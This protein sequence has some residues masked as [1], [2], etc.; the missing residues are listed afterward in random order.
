[1]R[2]PVKKI[3]A[4]LLRFCTKNQKILNFI[5]KNLRFTSNTADLIIRNNREIFIEICDQFPSAI[6]NGFRHI[7]RVL[8]IA[9]LYRLPETNVIIDIGAADGEI[10]LLF[11]KAYPEAI[12]YAFEPIK[13]AFTILHQNVKENPH[14]LPINKA[15]GNTIGERIIHVSES[16]RSSSIFEIENDIKNT[17][18]AEQLKYKSDEKINISRLDDEIPKDIDVNIVKIDVQ[19]YE[20]EVLKG[21]EL[22]LLRTKL[23]VLEMQNHN[24]YIDAPKYFVLDEYLRK[25]GFQLYDIVPSIREDNK[26]YEWDGIYINADFQAKYNTPPKDF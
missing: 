13:S 26:L 24:N 23:V 2:K 11:S 9:K 16:I 7:D 4:N 22:T 25:S 12:I 10:S 5:F 18:L 3:A 19:G 20:L 21:A 6:N 1:M 15:L 14:I 8:Y 17:Y